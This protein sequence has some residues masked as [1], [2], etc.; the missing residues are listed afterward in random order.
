MNNISL[1]PWSFETR[2]IDL[3]QEVGQLFGDCNLCYGHGTDNPLDEAAALVLFVLGIDY[4]DAEEPSFSKVSAV[5]F[6]LIEKL[7]E[8]RI[9][10]RKP[11]AFLT[12]EAFFCGYKFYVDER[13]L[14]PRS[15]MAELIQNLFEPWIDSASVERVL[16]VATGSGC[17]A[18]AIANNFPGAEVVASDVSKGALEVASI[19]VDGLSVREQVT[20]VESDL[21]ENIEGVFDLIVSNPPYVGPKSYEALPPEYHHEPGLAL[22]AEQNGLDFIARILHDSPPFLRDNG[23]LVLEM[24]EVAEEAEK[25]FPHPFKW[26]ELDNGGGGIA[27]LEAKHLK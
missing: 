8:Q 10:E 18:V 2:V 1:K 14:I 15:P 13:V 12:Q 22:I 3:I 16:D 9:K 21:F 23:I 11:L 17:L 5:E 24:G 4:S 27:V 7:V 26:V 20:L 19:N 25:A 6:K